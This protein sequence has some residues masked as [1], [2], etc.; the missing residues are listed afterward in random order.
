MLILHAR[1]RAAHFDAAVFALR[2]A[3]SEDWCA[4]QV[5]NLRPPVC[6]TGAL[7]LS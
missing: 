4:L 2:V 5:L 1:L 3:P 7:P 6:D